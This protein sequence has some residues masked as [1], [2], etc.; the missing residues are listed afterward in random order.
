MTFVCW[1]LMTVG[2][3]TILAISLFVALGLTA[4]AVNRRRDGGDGRLGP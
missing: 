4:A 3:V 1:V 2:F